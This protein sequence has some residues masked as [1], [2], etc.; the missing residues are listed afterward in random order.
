MGSTRPAPQVRFVAA[1]Y[2]RVLGRSVV[3]TEKI[4]GRDVSRH[5]VWNTNDAQGAGLHGGRHAGVG[6]GNRR[7]YLHFER[8]ERLCPAPAVSGKGGGISSSAMGQEN[9]LAGLGGVFLCEL[10]GLERAKQK[11][12]PPQRLYAGFG[13]R[14]FQRKPQ[15]GRQRAR[16]S[17]LG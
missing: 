12:F 10:R 2:E 11:L 4:G 7:E 17:R 5:T 15:C 14:Q 9:G 8:G 1:Q 16:R 6:I 13:R 3:A